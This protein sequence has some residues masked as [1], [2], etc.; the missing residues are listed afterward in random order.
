VLPPC[1]VAPEL[2]VATLPCCQATSVYE[3][4]M[5]FYGMDDPAFLSYLCIHQLS[6][7]VLM[8]SAVNGDNLFIIH[9]PLKSLQPLVLIR[10]IM[11]NSNFVTP[12]FCE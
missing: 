7:I 9:N 2:V 1:A 6:P 11:L 8:I 3:S 12:L 5:F 4:A 10:S